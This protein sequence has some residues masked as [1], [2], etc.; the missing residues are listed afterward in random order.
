MPHGAILIVDDEPQNLAA[1]RQVL[2]EKYSRLV[3]ARCGKEALEAAEKHRPAMILL[4]V[5]MPDMNGY[6]VCRAL[7]A[8]PKTE[9][10]PVIFVTG[11]KEVED[12]ADGFNAGAV[13]YITKPIRPAIVLARIETHLSLVRAAKLERSY[14]DAIYMLGMAGHYNDN[15]T[16]VH[17][18][19][20]AAYCRVMA[21]AVGWTEEQC[22]MLEMAAPMHDTGKIGIPDWILRKPGKLDAEEWEIMKNHTQIGYEILSR[23]EA[24]I[25]Q[26]A[27]E[28]ALCHHEKWDGS[29][30]PHGLVGKEIPISARIVALTDVFDALIMKRPYKEPWPLEKVMMTLQES[31]G[32]HFDP[33]LV[34]LFEISLPKILAVKAKWEVRENEMGDASPR[35]WSR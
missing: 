24:P 11:N 5:Q 1:L 25:F 31:S 13:D 8:N 30:Y 28:I 20:M 9:A 2:S 16:G 17:I 15:D 3:F 29:G 26:M 35:N 14:Q 27:A 6:E 12:E 22:A 33:D 32:K 34:K 23:S 19:R 10:V 18:W 4:D 7:K 21:K